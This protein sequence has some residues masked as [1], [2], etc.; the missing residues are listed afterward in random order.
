MNETNDIRVMVVEDHI[1][2][3][4]GLKTLSEIAPEIKVV[5]QVEDGESAV[6]AFRQHHPDVT[7][8]DLRL[9]GMDGIRTIEALHREFG[10]VP[11]LILSSH[12][13]D[14]DISRA[15]RA[16][17]AGYLLKDMPLPKLVEAIRA[18]H[19]GQQYF[20][21]E[22][23]HRL[24]EQLRQPRLTSRELAVLRMIADG[25]SNKEI[26]DGLGIVEGTVK[27]H[28][29]NLLDKLRAADRTQAVII[30]IKR[31]LLDVR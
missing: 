4:M 21:P 30:A 31:G 14:E 6:A 29:T 10:S 16:E 11:V 26:A 17:A 18:V 24:P 13:T 28:V 20:P 23:I 3:R 7:L 15:F 27:V 12:K 9:P 8:V 1:L 2:V 19:A 25:R 22:I 5:A